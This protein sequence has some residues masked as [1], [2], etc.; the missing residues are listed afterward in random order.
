[1]LDDCKINLNVNIE[2]GMNN[3]YS[4]LTVTT[5]VKY[6]TVNKKGKPFKLV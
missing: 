1:M 3:K 2:M 5:N 6:G 4:T